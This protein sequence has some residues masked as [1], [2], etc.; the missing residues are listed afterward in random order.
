VKTGDHVA[1]WEK[2]EQ[3][4]ITLVVQHFEEKK[5]YCASA[6]A[7]K[8]STIPNGKTT[9][10]ISSAATWSR[11]QDP[12]PEAHSL[13]EK[14]SR[15]SY[16]ELRSEHI[17][18]WA[19]YWS[20]TFVQITGPDDRGKLLQRIRHLHLYYMAATSRG[21]LP[22]KWNGS[23]FITD[24]DTRYWGSQYWVWTIETLYFP[25]LAAD[26]IDLTDPYYE[27]YVRQIPECQKAARQR[28]SAQGAFFPETTPHEGPVILPEENARNFQDIYLGRKS[29][30]ALTKAT[31][32]LCLFDSSLRCVAEGEKRGPVGRFSWISHLVSSGSELA[33]QFWWRYRYT[34]DTEWLRTKAYPML[35]ETAEFFRSLAR[36]GTDG[37]YHIHGTN[38]HEMF[39]GVNDGIMDL[40]AIRGTFPLAIRA[41]EILNVDPDLC[42]GW[43]EFLDNLAPYPMGRD[44]GSKA[45]VDSALADD[46]WSAGHL[47]E[48]NARKHLEDAW[49]APVFPFEDWTLET[50]NPETDAIV[51]KLIGLVP[52][53]K[54]I[55]AGELTNTADRVPIVV[56]RA[57][58]GELLP[59]VLEKFW[60]TFDHLS[61]FMSSFEGGTP[62]NQAQS[63][64]HLGCITTALQEG[65]LQSVSPRPG[66]PEIIRVFSAWP[67]K[68]DASFRLLARG[69]FLVS[70][71]IQNNHIQFV[72]IVSRNGGT[73]RLRNPWR[74]PCVMKTENGETKKVQGA[75]LCFETTPGQSYRITADEGQA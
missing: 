28:W 4:G 7:G 31:H 32:D 48:V 50:Q 38:V 49:L 42:A 9:V 34:G 68:W 61:N 30:D 33:I 27:M 2:I 57:G 51:Q 60:S 5:Y 36:K 8:V 22:A 35:R 3:N 75:V 15:H 64:E 56:A 69:N 25:L 72:E 46:V 71:A 40:A 26:A 43:R 73:C 59:T 55:L 52:R 39:W 16:E 45:L 23:L 11:S 54:T 66:E 44:P 19:E 10:L 1:R 41:A 29:F 58:L 63:V 62:E 37:K 20:R 12:Q 53:L 24:G 18:W 70:S 13:L 21:K 67:K 47:G 17:K 65:L 14:A 6:V 74:G